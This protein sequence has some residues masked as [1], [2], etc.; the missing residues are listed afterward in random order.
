MDIKRATD[1]KTNTGFTFSVKENNYGKIHCI[2]QTTILNTTM[3]YFL[4]NLVIREITMQMLHIDQL[5]VQ[6]LWVITVHEKLDDAYYD[7]TASVCK[8]KLDTV[9]TIIQGSIICKS[10]HK[11]KV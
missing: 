3:I 5:H 2:M 6:P 10:S 8:R 4:G 1:E 11:S 9:A 7:N